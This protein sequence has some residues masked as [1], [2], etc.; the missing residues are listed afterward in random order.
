[1]PGLC[2]EKK[3]NLDSAKKADTVILTG[4]WCHPGRL[5][6]WWTTHSMENTIFWSCQS[7][8]SGIHELSTQVWVYQFQALVL[9]QSAWGWLS[10]PSL[11]FSCEIPALVELA[12]TLAVC[13]CWWY[14]GRVGKELSDLS[15]VCDYKTPGRQEHSAISSFPETQNTPTRRGGEVRVS[16]GWLHR[17]CTGG[18]SLF[19][20][21]CLNGCSS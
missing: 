4:P 13:L 15:S 8:T 16:G 11:S 10:Y 18:S 21:L 9:T 1:M 5:V 14:E 7:K 12:V 3:G 19:C 17:E 6:P 20:S 2:S